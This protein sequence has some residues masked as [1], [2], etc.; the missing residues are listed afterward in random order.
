MAMEKNAGQV[1][2]FEERKK[3]KK[4]GLGSDCQRQEPH[5]MSAYP[6]SAFHHTT[7]WSFYVYPEFLQ[8]L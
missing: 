4:G 1:K 8:C 3:K 2:G 7:W 5:I 6:Q